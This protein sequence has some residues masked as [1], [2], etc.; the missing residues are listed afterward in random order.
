MAVAA[1]HRGSTVLLRSCRV[2]CLAGADGPAAPGFV[3]KGGA[4]CAMDGGSMVLEGACSIDGGGRPLAALQADG[5]GSSLTV[6]GEGCTVEGGSGSAVF[7]SDGAKAVVEGATLRSKQLHGS[8]A[9]DAQLVLRRCTLLS[10]GGRGSGEGASRHES[11]GV[12]GGDGVSG[13]Q[14]SSAQV[15]RGEGANDG[16]ERGSGERGNSQGSNPGDGSSGQGN[17]QGRCGSSNC[18]GW[19]EEEKT[20]DAGEDVALEEAL[21]RK[22]GVMAYSG[23]RYAC[24][25]EELCGWSPAAA[26]AAA[27]AVPLVGLELGTTRGQRPMSAPSS[28]T[29][30]PPL[31]TDNS[32]PAA[33]APLPTATARAT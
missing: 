16:G 29:P 24:L 1:S 27:C 10:K 18:K 2:C 33:D 4:V 11:I 20:G 8:A 14:G 28:Q 25:Q 12:E 21:A 6:R 19:L 30:P 32:P 17:Q 23:G 26:C 13:G 15:A 9:G 7:V 31:R 3:Q 5:L 22:G